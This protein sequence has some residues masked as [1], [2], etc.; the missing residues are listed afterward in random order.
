MKQIS[1]KSPSNLLQI[2]FKS[3]SNLPQVLEP[4][5]R[6]SKVV[7]DMMSGIP[8]SVR[9]NDAVLVFIDVFSNRIILSPCNKNLQ[10][11]PQGAARRLAGVDLKPSSVNYPRVKYKLSGSQDAYEGFE[12]IRDNILQSFDIARRSGFSWR[13]RN[14]RL[15]GISLVRLISMLVTSFML[16]TKSYTETHDMLGSFA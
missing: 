6:F 2:S 4:G 3:P 7:V 9:K 1:F 15:R 13:L 16:S 5:A 12:E 11:S 8:W 10:A 14:A